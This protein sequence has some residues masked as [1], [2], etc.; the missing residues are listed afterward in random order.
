MSGCIIERKS[1][2]ETSEIVDFS[3]FPWKNETKIA[4]WHSYID[5]VSQNIDFSF[6]GE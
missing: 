6:F 1:I 4:S 5:L 2:V 3:M